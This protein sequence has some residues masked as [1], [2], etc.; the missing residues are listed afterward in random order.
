MYSNN[1]LIIIDFDGTLYKKDSL[2]VFCLYVYRKHPS[3]LWV[4]FPQ[5]VASILHILKII[6]T[7]RYKE[8]FLLFLSGFDESEVQILAINFWNSLNQNQFNPSLLELINKNECRIICIS[9]SPELYLKPL[10]DKMNIELIGTLLN[11]S[12]NRYSIVGENCKGQEKVNRLK[13]YLG[14]DAFEIEESYS[15]S[16]SDKPL[17]ELSKRCYF[18]KSDSTIIQI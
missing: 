8:I 16:L 14:Y 18:V 11:Y 12:N 2:I 10:L 6:T 17:F 7:K 5:I 13:K 9:A 4:L 3:K 15:D 1:K